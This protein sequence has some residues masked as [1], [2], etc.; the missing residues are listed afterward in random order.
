MEKVWLR[1]LTALDMKLMRWQG[2]KTSTQK[3]KKKKKK[4]KKERKKYS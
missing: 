4:K 2:R 3:Q 1:K